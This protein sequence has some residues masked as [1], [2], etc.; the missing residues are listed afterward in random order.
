MPAATNNN[1]VDTNYFIITAAAVL[2]TW[3]LHEFAHWTAGTLL[4]Y[5]MVMTLNTGY[6][7][8]SAEEGH[9]QII[10]A[11]GPAIT[12]LQALSI[13]M[14]MRRYPNKLLYGFLFACLYCRLLATAMSLLNLNDEAR[15]SKFFGIGT[16][17]LPLIISAILLLLVY[18]TSQQYGFNKK[19]N[20]INTGLVML[21]SSIIILADQFFH[22]QLL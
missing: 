7:L 1:T 9:N 12:L 2:L 19:F 15:I 4:G 18:K 3:I 17:T 16:F 6:S 22:I 10:D 20:L 5:D 21:F 14:L 13:F 11:A 8:T